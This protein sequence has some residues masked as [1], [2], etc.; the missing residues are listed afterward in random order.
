MRPAMA[1]RFVQMIIMIAV[2]IVS[3]ILSNIHHRP[4]ML[5]LKR[6]CPRY[7]SFI[8]INPCRGDLPT[9]RMEY[10]PILSRPK[11]NIYVHDVKLTIVYSSLNATYV[12]MMLALVIAGF[13]VEYI[14]HPVINSFTTAAAITI[15][16]S[17]IKVENLYSYN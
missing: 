13:I 12:S 9:K 8:L 16:C 4:Y 7:L 11:V 5:A 3:Y 17:Q 14:S 1:T 15:I 10:V 2:A 6:E